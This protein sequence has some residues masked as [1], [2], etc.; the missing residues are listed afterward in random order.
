MIPLRGS[1]HQTPIHEAHI[2]VLVNVMAGLYGI[3][4]TALLLTCWGNR[5]VV[6]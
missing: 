1:D 3:L 4:F 6:K 5:R 2:L